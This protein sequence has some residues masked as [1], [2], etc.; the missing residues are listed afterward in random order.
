MF[1]VQGGWRYERQASL[2]CPKPFS[3]PTPFHKQAPALVRAWVRL[4]A[5]VDPAPGAS[6]QEIQA[7]QRGRMVSLLLLL[8]TGPVL[9][10]LLMSIVSAHLGLVL[11]AAALLLGLLLLSVLNRRGQVTL[12][13]IILWTAVSVGMGLALLSSG[14]LSPAVLP[15][16]SMLVLSEGLAALVLPLPFVLLAALCNTLSALLAF[17]FLPRSSLLEAMLAKSDALIT[18]WNVALYGLVALGLWLL[19]KNRER[20]NQASEVARLQHALLHERQRQERLTA[21]LERIE[22]TLQRALKG[23]RSARMGLPSL[24]DPALGSLSLTLTQM[25]DRMQRLAATSLLILSNPIQPFASFLDT[26][27]ELSSSPQAKGSHSRPV[28]PNSILA[29]IQQLSWGIISLKELVHQFRSKID[30]QR[31][32]KRFLLL[33]PL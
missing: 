4:T 17:A 19:V 1:V 5:P 10:G 28:N 22:Q 14:V 31:E 29:N 16:L 25:L 13:G 6:F 11:L 8:S 12:A 32:R 3:S 2:F 33:L 23:D 26:H 21:S 20:M 7:A 30:T 24:Q 15:L 27:A 9:V 18:G